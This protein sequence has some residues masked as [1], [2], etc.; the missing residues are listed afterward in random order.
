MKMLV[1]FAFYPS[2]QLLIDSGQF[3]FNTGFMIPGEV[4]F[5]TLVVSSRERSK[6]FTQEL[7][8]S[9]GQIA[10]LDLRLVLN[11]QI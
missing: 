4:Y 5:I 2:G 3:S 8:I 7:E 1:Y 10:H 9:G 11:I 6:S